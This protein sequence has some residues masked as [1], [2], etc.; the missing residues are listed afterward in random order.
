LQRHE[1]DRAGAFAQF[2]LSDAQGLDAAQFELG[3]CYEFGH[4]VA[5]DDAE[6]RRLYATA[7]FLHYIFVTFCQVPSFRRPRVSRS[8]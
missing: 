7:P 3:R 2:Q 1:E 6:A 4:G 8:F 5:K